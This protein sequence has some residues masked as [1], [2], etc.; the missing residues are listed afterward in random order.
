MDETSTIPSITDS[1]KLDRM[2]RRL[3]QQVEHLIEIRKLIAALERRLTML[4]RKV[5]SE[6]A[7][8]GAWSTRRD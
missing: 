6:R 4:E 3:D 2:E 7:P 1:G 8:T 5:S